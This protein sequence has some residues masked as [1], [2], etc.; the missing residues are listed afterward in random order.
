MIRLRSE[1]T[2][3]PGGS[4]VIANSDGSCTGA[5]AR[6]GVIFSANVNGTV[7][8]TGIHAQ[9][10]A[11]NAEAATSQPSQGK[12]RRADSNEP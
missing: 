6:I 1:T 12:A 2:T 9:A 3:P 4:R 7:T 5:D 8:A 11:T 10:A